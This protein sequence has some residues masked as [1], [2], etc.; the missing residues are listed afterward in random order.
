MKKLEAYRLQF[1]SQLPSQAPTNLQSMQNT[2][3]QLQA[4]NDAIDRARE[5]RLLLERQLDQLD[6]DK[7]SE[8]A[9][10]T[11]GPPSAK[12]QLATAREQLET[13][14]QRA[15]YHPDVRILQRTIRD[16]E[17]KANAE[18]AQSA[19]SVP[20]TPARRSPA[21]VQ[22]QQRRRD[23]ADQISDMIDSSNRGRHRNKVCEP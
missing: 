4:L 18:A 22:R 3:V 2:Q 6:T 14:L 17:V 7:S 16:L 20:A 10:T 12:Q 21:E 5:R 23:I 8:S 13:L 15:N 9:N 11:T 19:S 1:G